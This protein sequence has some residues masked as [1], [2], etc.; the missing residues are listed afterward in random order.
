[1]DIKIYEYGKSMNIIL[2]M[3]MENVDIIF[4]YWY[5]KYR[6]KFEH[7]YKKI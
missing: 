6:Y 4:E 7:G 2:T 1:M 5:E 3:E